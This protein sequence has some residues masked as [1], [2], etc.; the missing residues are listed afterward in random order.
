MQPVPGHCNIDQITVATKQTVSFC[1][2][3]SLPHLVK[4]IFR[5]T[6]VCLQNENELS[7]LGLVYFVHVSD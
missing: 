1:L 2:H 7:Y 3:M 6:L 4:C 5:F